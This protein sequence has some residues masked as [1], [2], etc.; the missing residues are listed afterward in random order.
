MAKYLV[1][2]DGFNIY[3]YTRRSSIVLES[4]KTFL[5]KIKAH[6]LLGR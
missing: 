4:E 2:L 3:S 1:G 6:K 5:S